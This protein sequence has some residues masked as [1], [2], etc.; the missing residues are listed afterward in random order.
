MNAFSAMVP[1]V[2]GRPARAL[3]AGF[4]RASRCAR[5]RVG[6]RARRPERK[7]S[8][9]RTPSR[10][11]CGWCA[12]RRC[13]L[14]SRCDRV[15]LARA[16]RAHG[17]GVAGARDAQADR[18]SERARFSRRTH[19]STHAH[20]LARTHARSLAR[21]TMETGSQFFT[22]LTRTDNNGALA[23]L[24]LYGEIPREKRAFPEAS[25]TLSA[26]RVGC[27][28]RSVPGERL[29]HLSCASGPLITRPSAHPTFPLSASPCLSR[30]RHLGAKA[31]P[32][33]STLS[34]S[35]L[36]VSRILSG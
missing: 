4:A 2:R 30:Q 34:S 11:R 22:S 5:C 20:T 19:A 7:H 21:L 16:R 24:G 12:L 13:S 23:L 27:S 25:P 10:S 8:V 9:R 15:L 36:A 6:A 32:R 17:P 14:A 35:S 31:R 28:S 29:S 26:V 18:L 33:S 3:A 1:E